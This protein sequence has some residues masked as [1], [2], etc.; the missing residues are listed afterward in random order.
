M[1]IDLRPRELLLPTHAEALIKE[2]RRLRRRRWMVA[3][4]V[5]V[6]ALGASLVG[7]SLT[8]S[9]PSARTP[10][11]PPGRIEL[12]RT[13]PTHAELALA[14]LGVV[15]SH[16]TFEATYVVHGDLVPYGG[17]QWLVTIARER[18]STWSYLL[19]SSTAGVVQWIEQGTTYVDCYR[20]DMA[21]TG[22]RRVSGAWTCGTGQNAASIG[23]SYLA[24]PFVPT[25]F[26]VDLRAA[27]DLQG[28][29]GRQ[30]TYN[31]VT[32]FRRPSPVY[33]E[34]Q[35]ARSVVRRARRGEG[36]WNVEQTATWCLGPGGLPVTFHRSGW[37]TWTLWSD[38][39]LVSY[40]TSP[41]RSL[42]TPIET[43]RA[44][45]PLPAM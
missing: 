4:S 42:F 45:E 25:Q 7:S 37:P 11:R 39:R 5:A 10:R 34:E 23:F 32:L 1:A 17:R 14:R 43:P 8:S 33:G 29:D 40:G 22:L 24:L 19:R 36:I 44:A 15:A 6:A 18:G 3:G 27:V 41:S 35:C 2:A 28:W 31:S 12:P 38:V 30:G 9:S 13:A 21:A 26:M 20:A 16:R